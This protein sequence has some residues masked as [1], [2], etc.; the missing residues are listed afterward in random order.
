MVLHLLLSLYFGTE[1]A[2]SR[3][4]I[5]TQNKYVVRIKTKDIGNAKRCENVI[6]DLCSK[7]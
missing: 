2:E 3:I 1:S 7:C 4:Y 5:N 6:P